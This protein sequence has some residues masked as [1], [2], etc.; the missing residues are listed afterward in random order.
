MAITL[1]EAQ[2]T[3]FD[4]LLTE[5]VTATDHANWRHHAVK[6]WDSFNRA[7]AT[8]KSRQMPYLPE[9]A[10][11]TTEGL[12]RNPVTGELYRLKKSGWDMIVSKYS[13]TGG[14]RRLA[15][16]LSKIEKGKWTRYTA[17]QSRVALSKGEIKQGWAIDARDLAVEY[18][19]GFCPLHFGPLSDAVSVILGYGPDC[20]EN[21]GLPWGEEYAQAKLAEMRAQEGR[22]S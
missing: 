21:N 16:D 13:K 3:L 10:P 1:S 2:K 19:Y 7:L 15:A 18:A 12:F 14:P 4:K 17:L 5:K 9:Y 6:D 8:L 20:A 11:A 22:K